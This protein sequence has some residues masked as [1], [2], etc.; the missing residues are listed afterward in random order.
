MFGESPLEYERKLTE[1]NVRDFASPKFFHAFKVEC[2]YRNRIILSH[3][4]QGQ[5]EEPIASLIRDFLM[6]TGEVT[7]RTIPRM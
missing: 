2:L 4:T 3:K 6:N 7:F 5:L 1:G